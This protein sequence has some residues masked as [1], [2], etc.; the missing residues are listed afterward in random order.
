MK[1]VVGLGNPGLRYAAT[2]HNVGFR[3][4][5]RWAAQRGLALDDERFGGR[6]GCGTLVT[7]DGPL[8]VAVLEP[9]DYMNRSGAPVAAA[10]AE[11]SVSDP[12]ADLL[13][14]FDDVDLP[15][16]RLR[17]RPSGS[18]GGHRGLADVIETLGSSNLPR[19][20][21]G[22]GRPEGPVDTAD[23]VLAPFSPP[24]LARLDEALADAAS[25]V[26]AALCQGVRSAM[27][28]VSRAPA[29]GVEEPVE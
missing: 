11:L 24:E 23:W 27:N 3:V 19:L 5:E 20:R 28:Q 17:L 9:H 13:I 29:S 15:F 12:S 14:V 7:P 1:L 2:R 18:A 21:F 25:A 8:E 26:D 22:V 10:V 6:F 4:V 16:G